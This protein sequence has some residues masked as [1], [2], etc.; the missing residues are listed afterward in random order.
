MHFLLK[1]A[2]RIGPT[3]RSALH[4]SDEAPLIFPLAL[5]GTIMA[6]LAAGYAY[7]TGWLT[8]GRLTPQ[9]IVSS[10]NSA[11]GVHAGLRRNHAK[12]ECVVGY[13]D[14]NGNAAGLSAATV[15]GVL[16]TPV[17]GRFA[18]PGANPSIPDASS[19]VRSMALLFQMANGEQWRTGMNS[20]GVFVVN[21]PQ[22]F[23]DQQLASVP[24]PLTGKPIPA[25]LQAFFAAH[26]ETAP[27]RAWVKQHKPS[28]TLANGTY[29][30]LNAFQLIAAD[31]TRHFVRWAMVP[32]QS[33][34]PIEASAA[35]D[36]NFLGKDL[37][38]QLKQGVVQWDLVLTLAEKGDVTDD[39]T[40][41]WPAG[42][43]TINAGTLMLTSTVAQ[44]DG[45]CRDVNFDPTVLPH[46]IQLSADPL[47]AARSSAYSN[48]FNRRLREEAVSDARP[49]NAT[50]TNMGAAQ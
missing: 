5:I 34:T 8:P 9:V 17:I 28:S 33:Y 3:L 4:L 45:A 49:F 38:R 26:P 31:G 22:G 27:F 23:Y 35:L 24:D 37:A 6:I 20:T 36:P 13:F 32:H 40:K 50:A 46:G 1:T 29:S 44:S 7:A 14:S 11:G 19:P 39:A 12:G 15:F 18:I 43:A 21:T 2:R 42:R 25:R 41:A 48:S 47:L 30:S 16:R 10:L